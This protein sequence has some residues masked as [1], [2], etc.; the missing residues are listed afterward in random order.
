[1]EIKIHNSTVIICSNSFKQC[2]QFSLFLTHP[3]SYKENC[4]K[5]S[6][7]WNWSKYKPPQV[8]TF[9]THLLKSSSYFLST[10]TKEALSHQSHDTHSRNVMQFAIVI[11]KLIKKLKKFI[12]LLLVIT[13]RQFYYYF[14]HHITRHHLTAS[15][16][17]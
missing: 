16:W 3:L 17:K 12:R 11:E 2:C 10:I 6:W 9:V 5:C 13:M 4:T 14:H 8:K 1:M 15:F 7:T